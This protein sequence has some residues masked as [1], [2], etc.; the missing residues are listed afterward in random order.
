V[1]SPISH[2]PL[3]AL[4]TNVGKHANKEEYEK[5][6]QTFF[7]TTQGSET[8]HRKQH[9][10]SI[11]CEKYMPNFRDCAISLKHLGAQ[12]LDAECSVDGLGSAL[13]W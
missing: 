3:S 1:H 2:R 10:T 12:S 5:D 7:Q 6:V 11:F 8:K 9:F 13:H 4:K